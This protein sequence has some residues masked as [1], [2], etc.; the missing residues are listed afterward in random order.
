MTFLSKAKN[1]D[2]VSRK[3]K[4]KNFRTPL[5]IFFIKKDLNSNL[6]KIINFVSKRDTIIRS[7]SISED[8]YSKSNAGHFISKKIK[9]GSPKN[10]ILNAIEEVSCKLGDHDEIIVQHCILNVS[11]SGVIFSSDNNTNAPYISIEYD[12]SGS[13]DLVTSGRDRIK[14]KTIIYKHKILNNKKFSFIYKI[15]SNLEKMFNSNRVDIEFAIKK[16]IFYFLQIRHL[17]NPKKKRQIDLSEALINIKKKI[18]KLK[19]RKPDLYGKDTIFSNMADWNPAEMIGDKPAPLSISLYRELITDNIWSQQRHKYGYKDCASNVLMFDFLGSPYIDIRTDLNSFLPKN[20]DK[21]ISEKT[22]NYC[23]TK[24]RR[25][26]FLHDKIEFKLI[27]SCYTLNTKKNLEKFLNKVDVKK[28]STELLDLTNNIICGD[29]LEKD[30]NIIKN[31]EKEL[32][33]IKKSNCSHIE[34]IYKY[35]SS[36]KKSGSLPFAGIARCAF[37]SKQILDSLLSKN[38]IKKNDIQEIYSSIDTITNK[39]NIDLLKVQKKK[40]A[41][42]SFIKKYGHIRPSM[43]DINSKNYK[44]GF[45]IYFDKKIINFKKVNKKR[46]LKIPKIDNLLASQGYKFNSKKLFKFSKVSIENRE[47]AKNTLSIGINLIFEE[48]KKLFK[49]LSINYSDAIYI[50]IRTILES[51]SRLKIDKLRNDIKK[52]IK[53]NKKNHNLSNMIQLPDVIVSPEDSYYFDLIKT[54]VNYITDN[55]VKG[56]TALVKLNKKI[57]LKNK[58]VLIKNADPGYD[59][60]FNKEI[61]GLITAY[62]GSNSHMSIR[63]LELGIPAAIGIGLEFFNKIKKID[64]IILDCKNKKLIF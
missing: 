30:I 54:K 46:N 49:E 57:T 53:Q 43:Y 47:N 48:L 56:K 21:K 28:Y 37:I 7:S 13:T 44:D 51:Y 41:K 9:K 59:F 39:I 38:L 12:Y 1:L 2:K 63:A 17:P 27:E 3:I 61:G 15:V 10:K 24:L 22:V 5:F 35:V 29:I 31:F 42:K 62:G 64:S 26:K 14:E 16:N 33:N 52:I 32:F 23:V 60:I 6:K 40:L 58:I 34:R 36:I 25:K 11:C 8:L 45:N 19:K 18:G 4:I 55:S 50:D 20:L